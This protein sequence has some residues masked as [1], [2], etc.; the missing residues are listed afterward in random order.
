MNKSTLEGGFVSNNQTPMTQ[1]WMLMFFSR[2][3]RE[4]TKK[5]V[6]A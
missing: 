3:W 5:E 4:S 2:K 1:E 6:S